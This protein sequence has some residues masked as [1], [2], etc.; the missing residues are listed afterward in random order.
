M[1]DHGIVGM[2]AEVLVLESLDR[3]LNNP[4]HVVQLQDHTRQ[5]QV[6]MVG[7]A[8]RAKVGVADLVD[9][10]AESRMR[11]VSPESQRGDA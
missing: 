9:V 11:H 7:I 10:H 3:W 5:A 6:A 4:L 8:R 2:G 1:Q